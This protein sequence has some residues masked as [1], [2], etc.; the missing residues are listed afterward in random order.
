MCTRADTAAGIVLSRGTRLREAGCVR[1]ESAVYHLLHPGTSPQDAGCVYTLPYTLQD[2]WLFSAGTVTS[3]EIG[4][5]GQA[6]AHAPQLQRPQRPQRLQR[7]QRQTERVCRDGVRI[8]M[9]AGAGGREE[10]AQAPEGCRLRQQSHRPGA[11]AQ[12]T[13]LTSY[14][15]MHMCMCMYVHVSNVTLAG[16]DQHRR[17]RHPHIYTVPT[18]EEESAVAEMRLCYVLLVRSLWGEF[19]SAP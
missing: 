15:H 11:L 19:S 7:L 13:T 18:G 17:P 4:L 1:P 14:M 5:K 8:C 12:P 9:R 10:R 16:L 2:A 6:R 3:E